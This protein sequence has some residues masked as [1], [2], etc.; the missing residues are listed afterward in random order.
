MFP[1]FNGKAD[2]T[3]IGQTFRGEPPNATARHFVAFECQWT[4]LSDRGEQ[5][6]I[7]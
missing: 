4:S 5:F 7:H 6:F 1:S 3:V 2:S